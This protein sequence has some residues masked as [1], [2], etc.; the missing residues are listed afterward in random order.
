MTSALIK[1][2]FFRRLRAT[3]RAGGFLS[4]NETAALPDLHKALQRDYVPD[5]R[6]RA[7]QDREEGKIVGRYVVY[8]GQQQIDHF[9]ELKET[10]TEFAR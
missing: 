10:W 8:A 6:A 2:P 3:S 5:L 4:S 9:R 1:P 7:V